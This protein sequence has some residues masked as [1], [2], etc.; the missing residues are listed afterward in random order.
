MAAK[1]ESRSPGYI[2]AALVGAVALAGCTA[3]D[4]TDT[5]DTA[6]VPSVTGQ[7]LGEARKEI[8]AAGLKPKVAA[9]G[10]FDSRPCLFGGSCVTVAQNPDDGVEVEPGS[11]VRLVIE[12]VD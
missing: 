11:T 4:D 1:L 2:V 6:I 7:G 12:E 8:K 10:P 3:T 9:P 5:G